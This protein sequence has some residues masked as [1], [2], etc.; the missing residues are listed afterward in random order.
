MAKK[1]MLGTLAFLAVAFASVGV[2]SLNGA[3][4][5]TVRAEDA[6]MTVDTLGN[7]AWT[8]TSGATGYTVS[9]EVDGDTVSFE[10]ES[11]TANVG[12]ALT[13]AVKAAQADGYEEGEKASVTFSVTPNGVDGAATSTYTHTFDKYIDYGYSTHDITEYNTD[14]ATGYGH[15]FGGN[16]TT[17]Y[18]A[19]T[20]ANY[21]E[22]Y[23][24]AFKND[25]LTLGLVRLTPNTSSAAYKTE[26]GLFGNQ[27]STIGNYNYKISIS[28]TGSGI[29][30]MAGDTSSTLAHG[31]SNVVV[32][33]ANSVT[34]VAAGQSYQG[35]T[36]VHTTT[37]IYANTLYLQIG[38]FDCYGLDGVKVSEKFY[39]TGEKTTPSGLSNIGVL[40]ME[41]TDFASLSYTMAPGN[42]KD[43]GSTGMANVLVDKSTMMISSTYIRHWLTSG[44]VEEKPMNVYYDNVDASMNW[45]AVENATGYEYAIG[46]G[47]WTA[48][49]QTYV[50]VAS[51]LSEYKTLGYLPF[52]VRAVTNGVK[53]AAASYALDLDRFYNSERS[54]VKDFYEVRGAYSYSGNAAVVNSDEVKVGTH[55]TYSFA[56]DGTTVHHF[57]LFGK[58]GYHNSYDLWIYANPDAG[59]ATYGY[60]TLWRNSTGING[61]TGR[62][63][64]D[65]WRG[66]KANFET[67]K[68]YFVTYGVDDVFENDVKVAERV[69]LRLYDE[70]NQ[71]I[72][73]TSFDNAQCFAEDN[74]ETTD[75]VE[76]A[77]YTILPETDSTRYTYKLYTPVSSTVDWK[78]RKV[79]LTLD[80]KI[81]ANAYVDI[82]AAHRATVANMKMKLTYKDETQTLE[83]PTATAGLYKFTK[84]VAAKELDE[85]ITL[86][87]VIGDKESDVEYTFKARDYIDIV[88]GDSANYSTE[89][90]DLVNAVEAYCDYA[91]EYYTDDE[92]DTPELDSEAEF[93]APKVNGLAE[94]ETVQKVAISLLTEEDTTLR[95]YIQA[96]AAPTVTVGGDA[97]EVKEVNGVSGYY[98]AEI[99]NIS[100]FDLTTEYTFI[101]NGEVSVECSALS[102][103]ALI[104]AKQA[105]NT[106]LV[107]VVKALYNYSVAACAYK[108]AN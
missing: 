29:T 83:L 32:N 92:I 81:G 47:E 49:T 7:L 8:A 107:N 91:A 40:E 12:V 98:Y 104:I 75:I 55:I 108:A 90:V 77:A 34:T 27:G 26:I 13:K 35:V 85:V 86:E 97:L 4:D 36:N 50:S 101:I 73:T 61:P 99:A 76:N 66:L 94:S 37:A 69:F 3:M 95:L 67:G 33:K 68:T 16:S 74:A 5:Q 84:Y 18:Y 17:A 105:E 63:L 11:N 96:T 23:S 78:L 60:V 14:V 79:S 72:L 53:G 70:N 19:K 46:D 48:T 102:Y 52:K 100:G 41:V 82:S 39:L 88:Q 9:Y 21:V 2:C 87:L 44:V 89:L 71:T 64:D 30:V 65:C 6:A 45:N 1:A 54:T 28:A 57:A 51:A 62:W 58:T 24:T 20:N 93:T 25:L 15:M 56:C 103:G 38:V 22:N 42:T 106:E 59:A 80:G 10:T 31:N 43:N